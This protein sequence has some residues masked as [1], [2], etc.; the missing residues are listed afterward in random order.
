MEVVAVAGSVFKRCG[1]RD[2]AGRLVGAGCV[3]LPLE[4]HGS[5]F[6]SVELA[7]GADGARRRL[8]RGG[9]W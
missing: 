3:L 4:G 9:Y 2:A 8:R 6:F 1:C 7:R 5:W